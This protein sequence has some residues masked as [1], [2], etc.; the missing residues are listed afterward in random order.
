MIVTIPLVGFPRQ[1][2]AAIEVLRIK[3]R[4]GIKTGTPKNNK[5]LTTSSAIAAGKVK[6]Y[7]PISFEI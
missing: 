2:P 3:E 4:M 6:F 1:M 5:N 7:T